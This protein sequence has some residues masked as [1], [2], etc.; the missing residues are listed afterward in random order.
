MTTTVAAPTTKALELTRVISE[1]LDT[2]EAKH[3]RFRPME[4]RVADSADRRRAYIGLMKQLG[5]RY[6]RCDFEGYRVYEREAE[7]R[8]S[9]AAVVEAVAGI[10]NNM[11]QRL[12]LGGGVLLYGRP[13]TGKD[14][15]LVALAYSA[16]L[17][18]GFTLEWINGADLYQQ[19]RQLIG[20]KEPEEAFLLR[21][22]QKQILFI[23][24]PIPPKGDVTEYS[25][26]VLQRILDRRYR[27]CLSTWSTLNVHGGL[28]AEERLASPLISRLRHNSVCLRCE[29]EDFRKA[30]NDKT[31]GRKAK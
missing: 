18:W 9:Q 13:G 1:I 26:G 19:A 15:L 25:V 23:S 17:Q 7:G 5:V 27:D 11:H 21:Y 6:R 14:H 2:A 31:V 12:A 3:P 28:E 10:A 8:P 4:P 22:S 24:D 16:I 20:T 30:S 29:W